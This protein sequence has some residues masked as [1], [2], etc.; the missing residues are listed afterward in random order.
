VAVSTLLWP[1]QI[2]DG[3][4]VAVAA[5]KGLTVTVVLAEAVQPVAEFVTVTV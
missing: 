1:T 2:V 3:P 4:A 5:G